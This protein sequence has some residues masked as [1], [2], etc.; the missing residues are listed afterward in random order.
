MLIGWGVAV[1]VGV[2]VGLAVAVGVRVSVAEAV[3]LGVLVWVAGAFVI[4]DSLLSDRSSLSRTGEQAAEMITRTNRKYQYL[5]GVLC[6]FIIF[7]N[8]NRF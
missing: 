3:G 8:K 6:F 2:T 1:G 5:G 4:F 7:T